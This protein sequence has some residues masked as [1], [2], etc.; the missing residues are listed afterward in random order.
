MDAVQLLTRI[1][2]IKSVSENESEVAKYLV[3]YMNEHGIEAHVDDAGNAVGIKS[4]KV[5]NEKQVEDLVLLGHMDTVPGD[6]P[7]RKEGDLLYG[8]GSVDAKGPLATFVS[9]TI[10]AQIPENTRVVVIGA[11]EEEISTS[12]GAH[13][14]KN[15]YAPKACV[16]GEPSNWDAITLGYKG[17]FLVKY[18]LRQEVGHTAGINSAVGEK[19]VIWWQKIQDHCNEYNQ[20]RTKLFDQLLPTLRHIQT[21]SDGLTEVAE[22]IVGIRLPLNIDISELKKVVKSLDEGANIDC[23]SHEEAYKSDKNNGLVR[24]FLK[25]I[26]KQNARPRFKTKTGTSDMNSVGPKWQCPIVA[27]GP[28]DSALDHT[29]NEHISVSE[30]L[31]AVEVLKNVIEDNGTTK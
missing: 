18:I 24:S 17:Q 13:Y 22:A 9:A 3:D 27:Y 10:Q 23:Y 16:I 4:G 26:R 11:V 15:Q 20:N 12:K 7:V 29:P 25:S 19:A 31:R 14:A 2:E 21:S 30:Y 6:I 1:V 5:T 8:R 28:G